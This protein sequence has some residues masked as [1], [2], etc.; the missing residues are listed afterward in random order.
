MLSEIPGRDQLNAG[1]FEIRQVAS[2]KAAAIDT[3]NGGNH[4][5]GRRY[6]KPLP[7]SIT[8]DLAIG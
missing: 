4:P 8:H 1:D 2:S 6:A 3:Y 7:E 5:I